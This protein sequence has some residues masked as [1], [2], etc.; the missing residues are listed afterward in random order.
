M[1]H[2]AVHV[3]VIRGLVDVYME[4]QFKESRWSAHNFHMYE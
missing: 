4:F 3:G 2:D 1:L